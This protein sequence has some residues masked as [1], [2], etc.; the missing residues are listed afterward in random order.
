MPCIETQIYWIHNVGKE[1]SAEVK[2]EW[3]TPPL[4]LCFHDVDGD[5]FTCGKWVNINIFGW[6][7][8][9]LHYSV[10]F[11]NVRIN[12]EIN[13]LSEYIVKN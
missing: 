11:E 1:S 8:Y 13:E 9:V 4:L 7:L 10:S 12:T 5:K 2:K 6:C 3:S